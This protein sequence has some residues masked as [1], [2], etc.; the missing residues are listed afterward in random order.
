M[1]SKTSTWASLTWKPSTDDV[2]VAGYG[3]YRN[4]YRFA[5]TA[6]APGSFVGLVCAT[7]YTLGVDAFDAQGNRSART[8]LTVTTA[9]CSDV[10]VTI[11]RTLPTQT[12]TLSLGAIHGQYSL[13]EWGDPAAVSRGKAALT[14]STTYQAQHIYGFGAKNP[15][16]SK[17]VFDWT[18]L[19]RRVQLMQSMGATPVLTLCCAPDWMTS[20][21]TATSTYPAIPPTPDHYQD[22]A[23]LA[24]QIALRYPSVTHFQVWNQMKGFWN[25]TTR[26]WDYV[27]YTNFYNAVYDALKSVNPA[28][29]VGGPYLI[30]EGTGNPIS[31]NNNAVIDYWLHNKHGADFVTFTHALVPYNATAIPT[32]DA[33]IA[34]TDQFAA[35]EQQVRAKTSLPIW[36]AEDYFDGKFERITYADHQYQAAALASIV[37]HEE[38]GFGAASFRFQPQGVAGD[39][40]DGDQESLFSDTRVIGGGQPFLAQRVYQTFKDS[41]P[42]GTQLYWSSSSSPDVEVLASATKTLLINKRNAAVSVAVNG[43]VVPLARYEVRTLAAPLQAARLMAG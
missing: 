21:G 19:D 6:T 43:T 40:Y 8:T 28:I 13:D 32:P 41:F 17:G 33:I 7:T 2:G 30:I 1:T 12:T 25:N 9:P 22:F 37:Y 15:E 23:D 27:A 35:I 5:T 24:R 29:K 34:S 38:L 3:L 11:K 16:V 20:L 18:S 14:A 10:T 4:G 31:A 26:N 42:P 39:T 36:W